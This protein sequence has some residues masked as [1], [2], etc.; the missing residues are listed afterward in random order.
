MSSI[1]PP[2]IAAS[3]AQATIAQRQRAVEE[4]SEEHQKAEKSREQ[5]A[6]K[7]R[8]E[9][10]VED[11]DETGNTKVRRHDEEEARQRNRHKQKQQ[12]Q[13]PDNADE[14]PPEHIDLQ[15]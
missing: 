3:V 7:D 11:A 13:Q 1:P 4:D 10:Q 2:N 8:Q 12:Y 9:H 5:Q 6:I 14:K 15:A